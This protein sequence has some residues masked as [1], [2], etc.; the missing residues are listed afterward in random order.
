[1]KIDILQRQTQKLLLEDEHRGGGGID[2]RV[3]A[4]VPKNIKMNCVI[5]STLS[6]SRLERLS[7]CL[8]KL[9]V[10]PEYVLV[11]KMVFGNLTALYNSAGLLHH[12]ARKAYVH[13]PRSTWAAYKKLRSTF[14]YGDIDGIEV[15]LKGIELSSNLIHFTSLSDFLCGL[16]FDGV[17]SNCDLE[18]RPSKRRLNTIECFGSAN[19][20][21]KSFRLDV[22]SSKELAQSGEQTCVVKGYSLGRLK[23]SYNESSGELRIGD[24]SHF[25][26]APF[27]SENPQLY[28]DILNRTTN[29]PSIESSILHHKITLKIFRDAGLNELVT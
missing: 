28:E 7:S 22:V 24:K 26:V 2:V 5:D 18:W 9:L 10:P 11:E 23:W 12:F 29:L 16:S 4:D 20:V 19:I 13:C 8:S 1:M 3:L 27:V 15:E 25:H 14:S 17:S 21:F 6:H